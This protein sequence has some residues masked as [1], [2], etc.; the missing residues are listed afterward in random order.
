MRITGFELLISCV[1]D[2]YFTTCGT[3]LMDSILAEGTSSFVVG[4]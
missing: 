3:A 4:K 2:K 1:E